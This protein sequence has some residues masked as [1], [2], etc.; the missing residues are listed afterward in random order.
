MNVA[1][2]V[3]LRHP[4]E[5]RIVLRGFEGGD[6]LPALGRV[7]L[8]EGVPALLPFGVGVA[9]RERRRARREPDEE[10]H[11]RLDEA[12]RQQ[13]RERGQRQFGDGAPH[14]AET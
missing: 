12:E 13:D 4:A 10:P 1:V 3:G 11:A 6:A 14:G 2:E 9:E 7:E 8:V 5:E